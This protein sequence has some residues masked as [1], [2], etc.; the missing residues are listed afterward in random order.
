MSNTFAV[1]VMFTLT[2]DLP[3]G[4]YGDGSPMLNKMYFPK[5]DPITYAQAK[6]HL[7][8]AWTQARGSMMN[9]QM[10]LLSEQGQMTGAM[11]G[12]TEQWD[13]QGMKFKGGEIREEDFVQEGDHSVSLGSIQDFHVERQGC[14]CVLM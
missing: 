12:Y 5:S 4:P 10:Q 7:V 8:K 3:N 9:M 14:S 6:E 11:G 2:D 1:T 13:V